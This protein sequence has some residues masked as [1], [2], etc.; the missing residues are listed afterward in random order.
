[1]R[2]I[3]FIT[4]FTLFSLIA[5]AQTNEDQSVKYENM[6]EKLLS[7]DGKLTIGGYAQID[8]NHPFASDRRYNGMLDIHRLVMLFGYNFNERTQFIT[9]IEY[10]HVTEVYIEQAFLQYKILPWLNFRG[11][12]MLIPMGI[13]N[14][15]HEPPT[16]NGVERPLIDNVISPTTWREIG[17]GFT[18]NFHQADL[19]YQLYLVNGFN[20]YDTNGVI[21]GKGLRSGRQKGAEAY[22]STPN[23]SGKLE[24]YGIRG[25]NVGLSGYFGDTQSKLYNNLDTNN[26][27]AVAR[28]DS[29]VVGMA[30]LGADFRF[31]RKGFQL[32]GQYYYTKLN[33]TL[34]YNKFTAVSGKPNDVGTAMMGYYLEAAWN[35]FQPLESVKTEL[36]PF[37]RYEEYDTHH[38]TDALTQIKDT[39]H[40]KAWIAG[41]GWKITPGAVLKADI[42]FLRNKAAVD[43]S[44]TF[45]AGIGI[46]F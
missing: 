26:P 45:N 25:L 15:Y 7:T 29:S 19:R 8:Y 30:M 33:N 24:Y 10:E 31:S 22:L 4:L 36:I 43:W 2:S 34:A 42:Q 23:L 27:G 28:A 32:R 16:Y 46:M 44:K 40:N 41:L 38:K 20:G 1:M 17:F 11:G 13:V 35:V 37:V 9:E 12:L 18:G 6:A 39:Y 5:H 14:E 3:F 21:S